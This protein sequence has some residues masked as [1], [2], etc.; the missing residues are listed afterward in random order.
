VTSEM[1]A[2]APRAPLDGVRVLDLTGTMSGPYC[3]LLL[4]QLGASVDK[5]EPA[6]G[7]VVRHLTAGRTAQMS[8]I[9]LALN[10]GKRSIVLDFHSD[11][12]REVLK[13]ALSQYDVVVHNMRPQAAARLGLTVEGLAD[14]GSDALLCE[15]VG[16]GP[17]PYQSKPAYDDTIQAIS[18][19]AW[20]QGNGT[21][22]AYVRSAVADKTAGMFAALAICAELVAGAT[23][24]SPRSVKVPMFEAMVAF[25][26]VEQL[27]GLTFE[28]PTGPALYPRTASPSRRPFATKDG[29]VSLMLYTDQHWAAFLRHV[30]RADLVEDYRFASLGGRTAHIDEAYGFVAEELGRRSTAEWLKSLDDMDVPHAPVNSLEDLLEDQHLAE[31]ELFAEVEHPTEGRIRTVRAPFLFNGRRTKDLAPAPSLGQHTA[32]FIAASG[33]SA[34]SEDRARERAAT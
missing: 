10:A 19:L 5:I 24:A 27:G 15:L 33:I 34:S 9:F 13:R 14:A 26:T 18:G 6:G 17:G 23:G 8:P 21:Q 29:Y 20:V 11:L 2:A 3:T 7:D 31:V 28:P 16:F 30:G 25:T 12:D 4:A 32:S 1:I 22:P